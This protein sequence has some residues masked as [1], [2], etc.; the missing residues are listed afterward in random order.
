MTKRT[1]STARHSAAEAPRSA[2]AA[3]TGPAT[4]APL[5]PRPFQRRP[6]FLAAAATALAAWLIFLLLMAWEPWGQ[7]KKRPPPLRGKE[8]AGATTDG[9]R[10]ATAPSP[11]DVDA[12]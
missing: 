1:R 3:A 7:A 11:A 5:E 2:A 10:G 6:W 4:R 12:R 8:A 9:K